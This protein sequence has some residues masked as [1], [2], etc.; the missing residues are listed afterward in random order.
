MSDSWVAGLVGYDVLERD[1]ATKHYIVK[2]PVP[3]PAFA[4]RPFKQ[5]R[6]LCLSLPETTETS[7]WGHP[8]FRAGRRTFC[9]FELVG[10]RP[11]IAFRVTGAEAERQARKKDFF[12]TPYGRALWVSRWVDTPLD[13]KLIASVVEHSYRQVAT[14]KLVRLLDS[15]LQ[16]KRR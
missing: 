15:R 10:G 16:P 9:T 11:S 3:L 8:N 4:R 7:S 5:V 12:L 6:R 1:F 2:P 13:L 14:K